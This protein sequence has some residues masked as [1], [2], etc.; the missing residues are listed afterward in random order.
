MA[1]LP[2]MKFQKVHKKVPS[3]IRIPSR[4]IVHHSI[5]FLKE[6]EEEKKGYDAAKKINKI[7]TLH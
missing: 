2:L 6:E 5:S 4:A 1:I 3:D 7:N